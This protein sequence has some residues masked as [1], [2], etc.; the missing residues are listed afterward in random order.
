MVARFEET[1]LSGGV[2][3]SFGGSEASRRAVAPVYVPPPP[4]PVAAASGRAAPPPPPPP[5]RGAVN[6]E[7]LMAEL[8]VGGCEPP[9]CA[10]LSRRVR[11]GR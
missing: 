8:E 4:P 2:R 1:I 3:F 7:R 5:P 10:C 9:P 11:I 6:G